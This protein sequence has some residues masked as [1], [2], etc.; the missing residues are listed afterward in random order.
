MKHA[1]LASLAAAALLGGTD[2]STKYQK[3]QSLLVDVTSS[4]HMETTDFSMERDGEPVDSPFGGGGGHEESRHIVMKDTVHETKDGAPVHVTREFKT[5][6]AKT[7]MSRGDEDMEME[8]ESPLH[9]V[10]LDLT[11]DDGEVVAEVVDGSEP[12]DDAVLKGHHLE[13]AL[14]ALLPAEDVEPGGKW[15]I[16]GEALARALML[17]QEG[18]F[19]PPPQ[20]EDDG[21][22]GR[23]E[24]R[25]GRGG[26]RGMRG[27]RGRR[28]G[29]LGGYLKEG[30]WDLEATLAEGTEEH[31]GVACLVVKIAGDG[32]GSMPEPEGGFGGGRGR[33]GGG[34]RASSFA[35]APVFENSFDV[36]VEGTLYVD[37]SAG[38]P[39][40]FELEAKLSTESTREMNRGES[41]MVIHN[42]QEG[43]YTYSVDL[44]QA[45][46][47]EE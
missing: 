15:D 27:M 46:A 13:L 36:E 41:S 10:T 20:R 39:V 26:M 24:G 7:V 44:S 11:L 5:V 2:L 21:G 38:R 42:A 25:G 43:T 8:A 47:D 18:A 32:S 33:R 29:G 14:D 17:D 23:G 34:D 12:D 31:D 16:D 22:A 45:P 4:F 3:D 9:E 40:H 37:P 28:G 1:I 30:T 19:F 35:L 6:A